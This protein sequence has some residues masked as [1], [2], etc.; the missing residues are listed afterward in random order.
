MS[1]FL[2]YFDIIVSSATLPVTL[3]CLGNVG[4]DQRVTRFMA[5]VGAVINMDGTAIYEAVAAIFIAQYSGVSLN[6]GQIIT[7]R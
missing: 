7:V 3:K 6:A 4:I 2:S 5:P 1:S